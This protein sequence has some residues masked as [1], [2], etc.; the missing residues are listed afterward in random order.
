MTYQVN[1]TPSAT[2]QLKK[3][4]KAIQP[5]IWQILEALAEEPRPSGVVKMAGD[6]L[7]QPSSG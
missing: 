7:C 5:L 4:P 3:S 1:L 2:R 6:E